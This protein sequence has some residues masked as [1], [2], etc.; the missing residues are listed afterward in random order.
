VTLNGVSRTIELREDQTLAD[1]HETAP[2]EAE[3]GVRTADV[4]VSGLGLDDELD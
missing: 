4:R 2:I 1:L 3:E